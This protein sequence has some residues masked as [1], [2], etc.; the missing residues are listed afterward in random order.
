VA[1]L[2]QGTLVDLIDLFH[3]L[4]KLIQKRGDSNATNNE[5]QTGNSPDKLNYSIKGWS[6]IGQFD[7]LD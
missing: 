2:A 5:N 1:K 7:D 4:S 3:D 6:L